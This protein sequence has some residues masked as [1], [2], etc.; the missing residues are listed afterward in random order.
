MLPGLSLGRR[1]AR[2]NAEYAIENIW[3]VT[4]HW[5]FQGSNGYYVSQPLTVAKDVCYE[6][7]AGYRPG[8]LKART[9]LLIRT[10]HR[11]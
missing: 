7:I 3:K 1:G 10:C 9:R 4:S 5:Q 6:L 8:D 11:D 2:L